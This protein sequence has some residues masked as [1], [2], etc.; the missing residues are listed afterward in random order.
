[1]AYI[2]RKIDGAAERRRGSMLR[3]YRE[4]TDIHVNERVV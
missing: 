4:W 2:T 1:V 3:S